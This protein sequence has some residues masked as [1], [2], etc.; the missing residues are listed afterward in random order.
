M[1]LRAAVSA[2][3]EGEKREL[4][5][6][7]AMG[8]VWAVIFLMLIHMAAVTAALFSSEMPILNSFV[9]NILFNV[10]KVL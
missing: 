5:R 3:E 9:L 7:E 8:S 2:A 10:Q 4:A 6:Y 1:P